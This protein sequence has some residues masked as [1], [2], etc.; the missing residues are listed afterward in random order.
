MILTIRLRIRISLS[1]GQ[2][3]PSLPLSFS[4]KC[5]ASSASY[6]S[7]LIVIA[8]GCEVIAMNDTN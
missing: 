8:E 4:S 7:R 2:P 6:Q 3:T 5:L 1:P